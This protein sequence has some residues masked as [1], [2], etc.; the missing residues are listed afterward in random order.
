MET[1][2][3]KT[4][5]EKTAFEKIY[6]LFMEDFNDKELQERY[7][8]FD[9]IREAAKE[10]HNEMVPKINELIQRGE[11]LKELIV[12]LACKQL[13]TAEAVEALLVLPEKITELRSK[14]MHQKEI[15]DEHDRLKKFYKDNSERKF[16][17]YWKVFR[18]L[19]SE[20]LPWME[21]KKPYIDTI[22]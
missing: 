22:I 12:D 10:R 17:Q 14:I 5:V 2:N 15:M 7:E 19:D 13:S 8:N 9:K 20:T 11:G 1:K 3:K 18:E 16:F 21:W 4:K 6:D